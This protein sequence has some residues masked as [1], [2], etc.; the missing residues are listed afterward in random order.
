MS[1]IPALAKVSKNLREFVV[2]P[3]STAAAISQKVVVNP[4]SDTFKINCVEISLEECSG[5]ICELLISAS[6]V[7]DDLDQCDNHQPDL[8]KTRMFDTTF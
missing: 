6:L 8:R 2:S 7:D 3:S 1:A 4:P 5:R